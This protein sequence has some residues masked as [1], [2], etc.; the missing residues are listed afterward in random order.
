MSYIVSENI[1]DE[2]IPTSFK[3]STMNP[4]PVGFALQK[5]KQFSDWIIS[6]I[7]E[8]IKRTASDKLRT[9]KETISKIFYDDDKTPK[10]IETALKGTTKTFRIKGSS[11]DDY[12]TYLKDITPRVITLLEKQPKPLKVMLRMQCQFRGMENEVGEEIFTDYHFNTKNNIVDSA[13]N[14]TDFLSVSVERL[15]ELIESLQGEG[16]GWIFDEVLHFDI[17]TSVYKP[18]AGSS[19]VPLP[20]FLAS[21]K[22]IINPKNSDRECFKWAVTEAVYPQKSNRDRIT[23]TSRENAEKFNWDGIKFPVKLSQISLFEKNNP[24]YVVNVLGYS[25]DDG[26]YPVRISKQYTSIA[27]EAV[28]VT[29]KPRPTASLTAINLMLLSNEAS[30]GDDDRKRQNRNETHQHYTLIKN[31]SRLVGMQTNKHNGK[32]HICLNCFNTFSLEKSFKEHTEVCLTNDSVKIE[33]P[34]KGSCIEF[35]KHAKKL[36]VPFV[37]Y[38]DFESYTERLQQ[39]C[40]TNDEA[41]SYPEGAASPYPKDATKSY[42]EKYQKHTPSGFCYYI[43]YR[44]GMYKAP[45]VYSGPNVAE[46]FC[47]QLELETRDI[48][49]KYFKNAVPMKITRAELDEWRHTNVC[50]ICEEDIRGDDAKVKDHCHLTGKYRGAAHQECNLKY[51]EPSFIPVI[52]HNLSGYDA[53]L[54]IK[55]LGAVASGDINC[56]ANTEEKY[57]SFTKKIL[58][59]TVVEKKKGEEQEREVYLNNRF[60]DSFKFMSCGLDSLV[61]NLTGDGTDNSRIAHTKNRFQEKT[62]LAAIPLCLRKGV[63]PYDYMDSPER[64]LETQLPPKSAFY[65]K[66]NNKDISDEDYTHAQ[67]I[68]KE[69]EMKTMKNYHDLYLDVLLL[70]DVFEN[71]REVCLNN[72]KLDPAWYLTAPELSWD[73]MLR[74]TGIKLELLTDPD[75][76]MMVENGTRGG[77][78]MISNRYSEANNKYMDSYDQTKPSKYIQYLDAN[79]LYGWAM[80]EKMPYKDFKWVDIKNTS[81]EEVLSKVLLDENLGYILEVDLE[82]PSE[83]HDLHNDYPL[84]PETMKINGV[85]KLT[86]NLRNKTKYILHHR[87]LGLYLSLGL[88]LTK[89]HRIIEFKQSG[90]LAPYIALNTDLRTNAKN[91][92]EKDFFKLMNNSVFGKTMENIRN[93]KDI[94]LVTS[95]KSAL[96]LI[97][98]PNFKH[99]TIFTENLISV[100]MSKTKLIFNKPVYVGMC[101]LDVSKTLMYNFHYNYIKP[102]YNDKALLLMTDTDSLCYEIETEDFYKDISSDVESKFDTS[103]YPKNHP[104]GIKTGVNKKVIGM[105]KDECSGEIMEGFVGLR[106]KLYATKMHSGEESKKCKGI[107]KVV[108]KNDIAFN[109]YKDVLFNQTIQMRKMNVIRSYKHEIYTET[110]NKTALSGNDDKW[111]VS[112]DRIRTMAYG[113]FKSEP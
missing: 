14:L 13:T 7:P 103:A 56:I 19:W 105:M 100:H 21:K 64:L 5:L 30:R 66:L 4:T 43:V 53:H 10:E 29:A 104:S 31:M 98:K 85:D 57:I 99:R 76:L 71:F 89:I 63:Y 40:N 58:V 59:E 106:A 49:D 60:I 50:H 54:F 112:S 101:I 2:P 88:K 44:G 22:A 8:P 87:N 1:L 34:K 78:S 75:M 38:A 94:K 108:T 70:A 33:M 83:L 18:L 96:K 73:A 35:D 48:Y 61:K 69:F 42:T 27:G 6:Y 32:T 68:W 16:S 113:H 17:L 102:K 109:D 72:Y 46:E 67:K 25:E 51:K 15:I 79:N 37:I 36:K 55:Q 80:S 39:S 20:K 52:F 82:Y 24:G 12:E 86:P 91:N 45:V 97:A 28:T 84:A 62:S 74:V 11:S 23:K 41:K 9:L 47:K 95:K 77:V 81:V 26:I 92:F 93:R 110:V 111:I 107:N 3:S 65:S 90:W